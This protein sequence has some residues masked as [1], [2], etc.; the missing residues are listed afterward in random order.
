MRH[1]TRE[2]WKANSWRPFPAKGV[3]HLLFFENHN[4]AARCYCEMNKKLWDLT[5]DVR[6]WLWVNADKNTLAW[7]GWPRAM[8]VSLERRWTYDLYNSQYHNFQ[9]GPWIGFYDK[10]A[11]MHFKMVYG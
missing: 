2:N 3:E 11:A 10:D 4:E 5:P 6:E 7:P 1:L 8:S 9:Y